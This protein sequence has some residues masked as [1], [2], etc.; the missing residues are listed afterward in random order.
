MQQERSQIKF[1]VIS[2]TKTKH[3]KEDLLQMENENLVFFIKDWAKR[4]GE[5]K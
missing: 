5:S 2:I 4:I 1:R 3:K